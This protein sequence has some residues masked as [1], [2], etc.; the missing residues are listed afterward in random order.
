MT[1]TKW[2]QKLGHMS[3]K[4]LKVL[5][6]QKLIPRLTK[7]SLPFCEHCVTSKQH[8]LKFSSSTARSKVILELIHFD[9]WQALIIS[10]EGTRY[11]MSFIDDYF[12]IYWVYPIKRKVDVFAVFKIFKARIELEYGKWIKCLRIDNGGEYTTDEFD[13]FCD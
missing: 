13:N 1:T 12:K 10:L 9:V 3:K 4:V 8:R 5:S 7:V 6:D 2:R 11:F